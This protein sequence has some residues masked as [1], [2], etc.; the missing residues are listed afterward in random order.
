MASVRAASADLVQNYQISVEELL[1]DPDFLQ[2]GSETIQQ[3]LNNMLATTSASIQFMADSSGIN[4]D[5]YLDDFEA[6]AAFTADV[7]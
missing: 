4:L 6:N 2:L 3:T 7:G 1:K 5:D